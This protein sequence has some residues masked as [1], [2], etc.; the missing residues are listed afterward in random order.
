MTQSHYL[1]ELPQQAI[2]RPPCPICGTR[3][4][5]ML[6]EKDRPGHDMRTFTCPGCEY[7]EA[8][9]VEYKKAALALPG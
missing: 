8:I 2:D 7:S 4:W 9:V 3:M 5:L 1:P 6:I